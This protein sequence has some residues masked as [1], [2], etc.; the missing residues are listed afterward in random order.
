MRLFPGIEGL[1]AK[2]AQRG[3]NDNSLNFLEMDNFSGFS[4]VIF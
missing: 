3:G 4:V 2:R 1:I